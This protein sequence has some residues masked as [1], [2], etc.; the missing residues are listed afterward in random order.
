MAEPIA[1]LVSRFAYDGRLR[2]DKLTL[3]STRQLSATEPWPND[4]AILVDTGQLAASCTREPIV[5]SYSRF[6]LLHALLAMTFAHSARSDGCQTVA[7]ITPY[8]AQARLLAAASEVDYPQITAATVHR[9]QGSE[10]DLVIFDLVDGIPQSGA[11]QLTG[12]HA[13]T[14][15]RL[16]NV[17]M[18]R[19]RGK[20]V[21]LADIK[22]IRERHSRA[23]PSRTI[24]RLFE[25]HGR[26]ETI[27]ASRLKRMTAGERFRWYDGWSEVEP[28]LTADLRLARRS[29]IINIPEA[30]DPSSSFDEAL[31]R[32]TSV[33]SQ[34]TVF[35]SAGIAA[36]LEETTT[37]DLRLMVQPGGF[38]S[39]VDDRLVWVGLYSPSGAMV[40]VTERNLV[41]GLRRLLRY[42]AFV[43]DR[44]N[45]LLQV[46]RYIHRNAVEAR[47]VH[48]PQDYFW[49]SYGA[50]V[51]G[52]RVRGLTTST[53]LEQMGGKQQDQ[54]RNYRKYVESS[55]QG[56]S[57]DPPPTIK[58]LVIGDEQFAE[59][60]SKKRR[61]GMVIEQRCTLTD[62]ER[63]VCQVT[64]IDREE[65]ARPQ[66]TPAINRARE[67]FMYLARRHTDASLR[68]VAQRLRV[69]DISTVS[70][71]EK[72]VTQRLQEKNAAAKE[73]KRILNQTCSL[74]QA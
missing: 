14:A 73:M 35:A 21:V 45:Y 16:L 48:R 46:S 60:V 5:G 47:L 74:I 40:R 36:R 58:Q 56:M 12:R 68:E 2:S 34:I 54:V 23:S 1:A 20:L 8:R 51:N 3:E 63:A 25:E 41:D 24:L 67:I 43:I 49:S 62:M 37:I 29:V 26:I 55:A 64:Q 39:F 53:V 65:L 15:F 44:D 38:F 11:S 10:R 70:H 66:R 17:A 9:F 4:A 71:G 52:R 42:K 32:V 31:I 69:R 50:Y 57:E 61:A 72:R 27:Q 30:F 28:V 33:C 19:A 22:F 6:N 18:S 7:M 59:E 13:D